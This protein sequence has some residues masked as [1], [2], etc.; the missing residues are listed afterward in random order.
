MHCPTCGERLDPGAPSCYA[1]GTQF[2][3]RVVQRAPMVRRCPRCGYWGQGV[4]YFSR[5]AHLAVLAGLS[6]F[7]YGI[8]GLTYWLVCRN[9]RVCPKCS[10]GWENSSRLIAPPSPA[11]AGSK[12]TAVATSA[13]PMPLTLDHHHDPPLPGGGLGR[14]VVGAGVA[15]LAVLV[16]LVGIVE[17]EAAAIAVGGVMGAAGSLTFLWG[18]SALQ[19]RRKA[20]VRGLERKVLLLAQE[21]GGTLTVSQVAADL[22]LTLPAAEKILIGMDDGFRVRSD[23]TSDGILVYEFPELQLTA[24]G[25]DLRSALN[26]GRAHQI[27]SLASTPPMTTKNGDSPEPRV[28]PVEDRVEPVDARA[29]VTRP[30]DREGEIAE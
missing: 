17:F 13:G 11:D 18:Y 15:L 12:P 7:T 3:T 9:R 10:F 29:P 1:C 20:L 2:E 24:G 14:R 16:M 28:Q 4:K 22:N 21:A 8:G 30:V 5:T 19:D 25:R 6:V 23:I 27:G 26:P